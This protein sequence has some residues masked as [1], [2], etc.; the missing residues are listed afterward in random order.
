LLENF[1]E[2]MQER[3]FNLPCASNVQVE[4]SSAE[5]RSVLEAEIQRQKILVVADLE[6][7]HL[8]AFTQETEKLDSWADDLK[9]GLELDIKESRTKSKGTATLADKLAA[10]KEQRDLESQREKNAVSYST[11]RTKFNASARA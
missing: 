3:L 8:G 7:R 1:D 9:V 2:D 11:A 5:H 4:T 6:T 10:Q